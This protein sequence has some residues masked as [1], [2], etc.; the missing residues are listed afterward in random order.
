[1][2][3]IAGALNEKFDHLKNEINHELEG[4]F[5][6]SQHMTVAGGQ[7][8]QQVTTELQMGSQQFLQSDLLFV[9]GMSAFVIIV[10]ILSLA[11]YYFKSSKFS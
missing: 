1:M 4:I 9:T 10:G 6:T 8:F 3:D 11:Y 7:E 5:S 2:P